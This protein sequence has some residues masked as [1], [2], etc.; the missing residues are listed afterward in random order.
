MTPPASFL[1]GTARLKNHN[2]CPSARRTLLSASYTVPVAIACSHAPIAL[3]AGHT[4]HAT[5]ELASCYRERFERHE[6]SP[7]SGWT[8]VCHS[9]G[10]TPVKPVHALLTRKRQG[11]SGVGVAIHASTGRSSRATSGFFSHIA[12]VAACGRGAVR[13]RTASAGRG[14]SPWLQNTLPSA[15]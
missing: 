7:S 9:S 5:V 11:P 14:E 13:V 1:R 2:H 3:T 4:A 10:N 15:S 12:S 8:A 6:H